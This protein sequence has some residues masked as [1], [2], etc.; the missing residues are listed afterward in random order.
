M[1][2]YK[3]LIGP[4]LRA[5]TLAAQQVEA[6]LDCSVSNRMTELGRPISQRVR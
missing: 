5:R 2:R 3:S 4:R 6:R 1:F